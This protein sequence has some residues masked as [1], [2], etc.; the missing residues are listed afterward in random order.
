M[1]NNYM[2][3]NNLS[4]LNNSRLRNELLNLPLAKCT[5]EIAY[6]TTAQG[7]IVFVKGDLPTDD[8]IEPIKYTQGLITDKMKSM[9]A[10]D[11]I[12]C[13]GFGTGYI[14]DELSSAVKSK[15]VI[16]EPDTK[17]LRFVFNVIFI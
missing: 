5:E 12:V 2:F 8:T 14:L 11:I 1:Y 17:F 15:I 6:V 10:N 3:Q 9:A 13:V 4:K 7:D 16:Y